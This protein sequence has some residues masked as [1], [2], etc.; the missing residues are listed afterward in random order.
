MLDTEKLQHKNHSIPPGIENPLTAAPISTKP[1]QIS[2][3]ILPSIKQWKKC[4]THPPATGKKK[5]KSK[6]LEK[7]KKPKSKT[8]NTGNRI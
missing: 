8:P 7:K 4:T 6:S 1:D 5:K 3:L 2:N